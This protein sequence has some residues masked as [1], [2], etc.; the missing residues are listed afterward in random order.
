MEDMKDIK[1]VESVV[2]LSNSEMDR[3]N[4]ENNVYTSFLFARPRVTYEHIQ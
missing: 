1:Q 4:A 2:K 3:I